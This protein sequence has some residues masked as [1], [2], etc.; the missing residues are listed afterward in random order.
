MKGSDAQYR[1]IKGPYKGVKVPITGAISLTKAAQLKR[2]VDECKSLPRADVVQKQYV[3][4]GEEHTR[5]PVALH[6]V[7]HRDVAA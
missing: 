5:A 3:R 6:Q 2:E 4:P 7:R 1:G